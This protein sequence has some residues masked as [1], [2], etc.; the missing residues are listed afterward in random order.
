VETDAEFTDALAAELFGL[1]LRRLTT[2]SVTASI[3]RAIVR[4]ARGYGWHVRTEARVEVPVAVQA[5]LAEQLGF[6]DV[7]VSRGRPFPDVA[8]EI[9]STDKP[10]SVVKLQHVAAAGMH[11]IWVRWG[12]DAWAGMYEHI[13]VIQLPALRRTRT[14]RSTDQLTVWAR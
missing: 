8:I 12:D 5:G 2:A 1:D 7:L 10:W 11:A 4:M 6:V 9:D 14:R 3:T 13:D